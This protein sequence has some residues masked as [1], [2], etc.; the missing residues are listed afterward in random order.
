MRGGRCY[1]GGGPLLHV[2][3]EGG[4]GWPVLLWW[5]S[6]ITCSQR[7]VR[8]GRCYCGGGPLLHVVRGR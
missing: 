5:R 7:A 1:C 2:E 6:P 3:S 8:G 4:E